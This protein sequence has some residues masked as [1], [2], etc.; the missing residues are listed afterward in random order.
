[1]LRLVVLFS[2]LLFRGLRL[3]KIGRGEAVISFTS[4][5]D[6]QPIGVIYLAV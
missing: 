4:E 1:M 3:I 6:R 2:V 5:R